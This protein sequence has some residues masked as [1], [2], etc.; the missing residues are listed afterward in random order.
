MEI[1]IGGLAERSGCKAVAIRYY[2]KEGLLPK[3]ARSGG[4]SNMKN[5]GNRCA[6]GR[7]PTSDVKFTHDGCAKP[8]HSD[9]H[10][11]SATCSSVTTTGVRPQR[12]GNGIVGVIQFLQN[13]ALR[14][15]LHVMALLTQCRQL[16][17]QGL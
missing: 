6:V 15:R 10:C 14:H 16:H 3:P 4:N 8:L 11:D 17:L 2:E 13:A 5:N 12:C 1:R 9:Q 7:S